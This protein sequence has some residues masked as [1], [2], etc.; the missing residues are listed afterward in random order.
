MFDHLYDDFKS[1]IIKGK[2]F[3][4]KWTKDKCEIRN[5]MFAQVGPIAIIYQ[6]RGKKLTTISPNHKF[7]LLEILRFKKIYF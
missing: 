3:Q 2:I 7:V 6:I 1:E 5:H 4:I